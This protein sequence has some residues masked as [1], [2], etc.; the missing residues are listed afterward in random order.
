MDIYKKSA[1]TTK[2]EFQALWLG[3]Y[4]H[5]ETGLEIRV[6]CP[7]KPLFMLMSQTCGTLFL[8]GVQ[9]WLGITL[10]CCMTRAG[11]SGRYSAK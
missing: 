5:E 2:T 7:N 6:L 11:E 8:R 1:N 4:Q 10:E 3:T 9:V